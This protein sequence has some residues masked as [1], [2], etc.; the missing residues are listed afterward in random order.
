MLV[1]PVGLD[2]NEVR[3]MPWVTWVLIGTCFVVHLALSTVGAEAEHETSQR[4]KESL[5]YLGE[6]PYL[7]PPPPLLELLGGEGRAE[8]ERMAAEWE[9]VEGAVPAGIA[10]REQQQLNKLTDAAF[11]SLRHL[12]SS[13]LGFAPARPNPFGL[14][15]YTFV[16]AGWF[17]LIGNMWFLFLTG[18][19]IEDLF[20]RP[21]FGVLYFLSGVA[22]A[23]AFAAGAPHTEVVLVGASGAI[24]GVMGAFL[25]R[26]ATRRIEFLVMPVPIIPAFRFHLKV[27]AFV[28]IPLWAA[29]QLYYASVAGTDSSVAFSAHV[30]GFV[31]GLIFAGVMAL[32]SVEERFVNPAIEREISIEQNPV[33]TRAADARVAGDL[34]LARRL[35]DGVI[36]TEPGNVDAWTESWE[37][38]LEASDGERA[39]QSGLRLLDLHGR[40][41]DRDMV[42][43]VVND[44]RWRALRMPSRFLSTVADLLARAGDARE[45]IEIYRR[46]AAEAPPGDVAALRA[47]VSEGELLMRAGDP[48]AA[49]Q[50]FDRARTHPSCSE[51]WVERMER[52]LRVSR[53]TRGVGP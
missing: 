52:A 1:L 8:L 17:H 32:L 29:E 48:K 21:L 42:W 26:L 44:P 16:H 12:P 45:A 34:A 5:Q 27:P 36:R 25:V 19:F 35:I 43:G 39:G 50:A 23:G 22:G 38:A 2:K 46:Q 33:I 49:R 10:E 6:H 3:R 13:R 30:G 11:E 18:P 47:L 7:S 40:G 20:G 15:T 9:A 28:V 31:V 51:P 41:A 14:V 24:A 37:T 4:V 53:P